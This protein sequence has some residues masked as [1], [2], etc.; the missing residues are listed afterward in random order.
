ME[1]RPFLFLSHLYH[2]MELSWIAFVLLA[3]SRLTLQHNLARNNLA[4]TAFTTPNSAGLEDNYNDDQVY[5]LNSV[6]DV[7]WFTNFTSYSVYLWQ[8]DLVG[9]SAAQSQAAIFSGQLCT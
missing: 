4:N 3:C 9:G 5:L 6:L 7:S 2:S 8:Q 1:G